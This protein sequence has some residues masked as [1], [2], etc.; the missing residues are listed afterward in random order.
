MERGS[1]EQRAEAAAQ[2]VAS[3]IH[4]RRSTRGCKRIYVAI[5][6][7]RPD[8]NRLF[9]SCYSGSA[10]D[11]ELRGYIRVCLPAARPCCGYGC[12]CLLV[13]WQG[14]VRGASE[15]RSTASLRGSSS[16]MIQS[17]LSLLS[18]MISVRI[19]NGCQHRRL[20]W[21][22]WRVSEYSGT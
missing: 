8:R 3:T 18:E 10:R 15:T 21:I 16:P 22:G 4:D 11:K 20:V 12:G 13:C 14:S 19:A 1:W 7:A 17:R 9:T 5:G 2:A 6:Q